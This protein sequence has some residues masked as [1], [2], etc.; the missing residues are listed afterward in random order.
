MRAGRLKHW[1]VDVMPGSYHPAEG[2]VVR[3]LR[4]DGTLRG[5]SR[6]VS[7]RDVRVRVS[8]GEEARYRMGMQGL[9]ALP[10]GGWQYVVQSYPPKHRTLTKHRSQRGGA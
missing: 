2:Q 3:E 4:H 9:D 6:I 1:T 7:L 8:R 5:Y 10:E